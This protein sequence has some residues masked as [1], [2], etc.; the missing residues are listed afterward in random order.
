M[1]TETTILQMGE[2]LDQLAILDPK[3]DGFSRRAYEAARKKCGAPLVTAAAQ[4]LVSTVHRGDIVYLL[5]GSVLHPPGCAETDGVAGSVL[6]ARALVLA[7]D[8]KPVLVVGEEAWEA[9]QAMCTAV[10]LHCYTA[11]NADHPFEDLKAYPASVAAVAFPKDFD[12]D[13]LDQIA[14]LFDDD[15]NEAEGYAQHLLE[16]APPTA[17]I[18]VGLTETA[19]GDY[20]PLPIFIEAQKR[21]VPAI[22][23]GNARAGN[24]AYAT[25]QPVIGTLHDWAA[26]ALIAA[27]AFITETPGAFHDGETERRVLEAGARAGL[28]DTDGWHL[29][30]IGGFDADFHG[31]FVELM[32]HV[33]GA[34]GR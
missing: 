26:Y 16:S 34:N 14:D 20:S 21:G 9:V 17:V 8:A 25:P 12:P 18:A 1:P 13:E 4:R 30:G 5:A 27:L 7:L 29:P 32:G 11:D 22:A 23:I 3:G 31:A 15:Q 33:I 10:G 24:S 2:N 28:V 6:L 19:A